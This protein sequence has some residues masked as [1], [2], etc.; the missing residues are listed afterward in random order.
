MKLKVKGH[1]EIIEVN[2]TKFQTSLLKQCEI[3]NRQAV[4][5]WLKEVLKYIPGYTGT[6]RGTL[7][8]VGRLIN[9]AVARFG[10]SGPSGNQRRAKKKKWINYKGRMY[11]AGFQFGKQYAE[12]RISSKVTGITILNSFEFDNNLPYIARNDISGPPPNFIMPSN[13]PWRSHDKAAEAWKNYILTVAIKRL[14]KIKDF[15]KIKRMKVR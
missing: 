13:P 9:R 5:V 4:R 15:L 11:R 8:P 12:A 3:Q 10:P 2:L 7:V 6:A 1:I 14:P